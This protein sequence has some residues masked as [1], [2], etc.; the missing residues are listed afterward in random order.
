MKV[1][2]V[3][4]ALALGVC[5][6]ASA[7]TTTANVQWAAG[8]NWIP[9]CN[10]PSNCPANE[11]TAMS[12][13]ADGGITVGSRAVQEPNLFVHS[14]SPEFLH[15]GAS[16]DQSAEFTIANA[17]PPSTPLPANHLLYQGPPPG[18]PLGLPPRRPPRPS[19]QGAHQGS[20]T[21]ALPPRL[22]Y[23]GPHQGSHQGPHQG[24]NKGSYQ[25]CMVQL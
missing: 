17:A 4:A 23:Q 3:F 24:S 13:Q 5:A 1:L 9:D 18:L 12:F 14:S 7:G 22:S 6:S 2:A 8:S 20:P 25:W 11:G 21:R 10:G 16:V 15:E 19:H